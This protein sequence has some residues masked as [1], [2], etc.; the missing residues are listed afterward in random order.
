[1]PHRQTRSAQMEH[2]DRPLVTKEEISGL[3]KLHGFLKCGNLVV[4]PSFPYFHLPKRHLDFLEREFPPSASGKL[5]PSEPQSPLPA[6]PS[7]SS[8]HSRKG[9]GSENGPGQGQRPEGF[10]K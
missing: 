5:P 8:G 6:A 10:M 7:A 9:D 2:V 4:R 3:D 1:M